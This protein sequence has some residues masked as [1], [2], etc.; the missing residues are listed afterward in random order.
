MDTVIYCRSMF[1]RDEAVARLNSKGVIPQSCYVRLGDKSLWIV[2]GDNSMAAQDLSLAIVAHKKQIMKDK[3]ICDSLVQGEWEA[4][5]T[6]R[7]CDLV[8]S[9][10][11]IKKAFGQ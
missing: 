3:M 1:E 6:M 4:I 2:A 11:R 8:E 10:E 9:Q 7:C 5:K